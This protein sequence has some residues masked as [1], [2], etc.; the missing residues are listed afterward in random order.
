M[1]DADPAATYARRLAER[2]EAVEKIRRVDDR[3]GSLGL[4]CFS[5]AALALALILMHVVAPAWILPPLAGALV[6]RVLY[7]RS[8]ARRRPLEFG[9][10]YCEEGL[11][12]VEDRWIGKG[13]GG[14]DQFDPEHPY[15]A[16]LD[17]FG[18]GSL[19]E[20]LNTTRTRT[21]EATL[22]GWLRAP[23]APVDIRARQEAVKDLRDGTELR[24]E[25][26]LLAE[27]VQA[28]VHPD[29]LGRWAAEPPGLPPALRIWAG[30]LT[31]GTATA[32]FLGLWPFVIAVFL[33]LMTSWAA[34]ARVLRVA[35][36]AQRAERELDVLSKILERLERESFQAPRLVE[37]GGRLRGAAAAIGRLVRWIQ[38]LQSA[39]NELVM[40]ILGL[41]LW[42]LH[43]AYFLEG[44]RAKHGASIAAWLSA[45]GEIDA[46]GALA[47]YAWERPEDVFPEIAEAGPVYEGEGLGHPLLPAKACVRNDVRL[48]TSPSVLVVSGSNM[49][50]KSTLLR[51]VGANAV[52][53]LAGAPV[54]AR[55]L[56]M[57]PLALG[58]T[59]RVQDSLQMGTSRFYAEVKR[60]KQ[61]MD[62]AKGE[63]PLL[64]LV[65]ELLS[66]TNSH[67]RQKGAEI[68]VREFVARGAI[69]LVTTHDLSLAAAGEALGGKAANVHFEDRIEGG[70]LQFDYVLRPGP[71]K[72]SNALELMRAVGLPV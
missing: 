62:L 11:A 44:W 26:A 54:R 41:F 3:W 71:V 32:C 27:D 40:A 9:I 61:L 57:S 55:R 21:G 47:G 64:F 17:V 10:R 58:S 51:T 49:S 63:R 13:R 36:L 33:V 22:A 35:E 16:D 24:E 12:R 5:A 46:L 23:A 56:R 14:A 37:M 42:R 2:R 34:R 19:F 48:G 25:L 60:L 18:S 30:L 8:A 66:G 20:R 45:T 69:G 72:G 68:L 52:L 29:D 6:F 53:A 31:L 1:A 43:M 59:I 28:S 70:K 65:E 4:L 15:A 7:A 39:R 50:G 67:D 38:L